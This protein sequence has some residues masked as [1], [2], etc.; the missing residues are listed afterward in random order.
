MSASELLGIFAQN[1]PTIAGNPQQPI[2]NLEDDMPI[3]PDEMN[4]DD[5]PVD[6]QPSD[7]DSIIIPAI[8][9]YL[10]QENFKPYEIDVLVS[11]KDI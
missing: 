2:E 11:S 6:P 8:R 9:K 5:P 4:P 1:L 10:Q 3:E 7:W